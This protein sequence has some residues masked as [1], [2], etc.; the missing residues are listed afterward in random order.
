MSVFIITELR[1]TG[2]GILES[3]PTVLRWTSG[4]HSAPRGQIEHALSVKTVRQEVPGS[5]EPVEQV[6]A[7]TWQPFPLDGVWDDRYAGAGFAARAYDEVARLVQRASLVRLQLDRLSFVGIITELKLGYRTR[8]R[9][10]WSIVVSPHRNETV[11]EVRPRDTS[12]SAIRPVAHHVAVATS[13]VDT[14]TAAH[15]DAGSIPMATDLHAE[16]GEDLDALGAV[17]SKLRAASEAGFEEEA[18]QRLLGVS[19]LFRAVR[20][21]A[22]AIPQRFA[23]ARSTAQVAYGDVVQTL[24]FEAWARTAG[25]DARRAIWGAEKASTDLRVQAR[26][27]PRAVHRARAGESLK[28]ISQRYYGTADGWRAIYEANNLASLTLVGTEELVIP[29]RGR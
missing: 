19:A 21:A 26:Q 24:R 8:D 7:A 2:A 14:L 13:T 28:R 10:A 9:I 15:A 4:E 5:E 1:R 17:T 20:G 27:R 25:A 6:L 23:R 29:E 16:A 22:Q 11:G 18:A 12:V 3:T